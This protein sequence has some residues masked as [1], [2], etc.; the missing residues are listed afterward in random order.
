M[1]LTPKLPKA[2]ESSGACGSNLLWAESCCVGLNV[3][4]V[5]HW[6]P[7]SLFCKQAVGGRDAPQHS[8]TVPSELQARGVHMFKKVRCCFTPHPQGGENG[9]CALCSRNNKD[10]SA[11]GGSGAMLGLLG[12]V[13]LGWPVVLWG[14]FGPSVALQSALA[15]CL[16]ANPVLSERGTL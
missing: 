5:C 15:L 3:G 14:G 7:R 2:R 6:K 13:M 1:Y 9:H 11:G 12:A 16:W 10:L 4:S 8:N